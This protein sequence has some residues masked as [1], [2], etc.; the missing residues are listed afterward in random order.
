MKDR[1]RLKRIA[2]SKLHLPAGPAMA[3]AVVAAMLV[4]ALG[5]AGCGSSKKAATTPAISKAQLVAQG[6]AICAEGNQKLSI[7]QKS[8]EKTFA[9][10][11]PSE[12][13]IKL[14]VTTTF[15][16]II[17][18]QIDRIKALGAPSGEQATV[19]GA[20]ALAQADLDK[21]KSNP[22]VLL[23]GTPP[24]ATFARAAHA[25]GLTACAAGQ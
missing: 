24:F 11:A 5:A 9:N 1:P 8:L 20:L 22:K 17:Q 25:Y 12:A 14:Y 13:Q 15:A 23:G 3:A 16:P 10:H 6:N 4:I 18:S 21:V 7:V 2:A 19:T